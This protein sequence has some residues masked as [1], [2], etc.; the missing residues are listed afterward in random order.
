MNNETFG[1][2]FQY[3][4]C[5]KYN[6]DN[7][8]SK[9]RIDNDLLEKF[10]NSKII[11][12]IFR[13]KKPIKYLSDSKEY[14]ST[15]IKKCPHNFLLINN[16]TFSVKTFKGKGK[17]FAPKVVG[18]SG[19]E[20]FN[21]FF[22]HLSSEVVSR[23]N[24][25]DFCL[26]HID[27]MLPILIDYALISD[28]NC[29]FYLN[30]SDFDYKTIKREDL[31]ELTF[32]YK[33]FSFTKKIAKDWEDSNTVKYKGKTI[34]EIQQ[35]K[36]RKGYKIRLHRDNFPQLLKTEKEINNS[37][38][39][40]TA[41]LAICNVF[42]INAF[43]NNERLLNNSDKLILSAF[44]NH[45]SI[46]KAILFPNKPIKYSGSEKRDRGGSSKSGV[47]FFLENNSTLS[48]KTNK[49]K[50]FKV[51]PP[52]IGQPTPKT[53]DL[54]FSNKRWY[55]G[56]IN[57]EKFRSLVR[58]REKLTLLL[59]E[60]VKFL[61][62]C[63]YIL[64]SVYLNEKNISS[65]L[66]IKSQLENL[67][68]NSKLIDYSND[69]ITKSSVTIKYGTEGLSLGEFQVHSARNSLKFRFNLNNLLNV[70]K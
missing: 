53:F 58:D 32:E 31:P 67:K 35:H 11:P 22:G 1:L 40:D 25:K 45:Y 37:L 62:E 19:D 70:I 15:F 65:K 26:N 41:E 30:E 60:Y 2:T 52:E 18:Q 33:D 4:I 8:I 12:K 14:T 29:W 51:C 63:D 59:Y 50:A 66:V 43:E 7:S 3:A 16:Q 24:F 55:D 13:G 21:H 23:K 17:M 39:G 47:D 42:K 56:Q 46:N 69:F 38:L 27:D 34:I 36:N 20:T 6:L 64:W 61:N 10:L 5:Q 49:S 9:A 28:L 48:V 68:F 54:Y 57:E 44:E